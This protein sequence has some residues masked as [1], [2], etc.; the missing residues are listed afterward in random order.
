MI[1]SLLAN[2]KRTVAVRASGAD[3]PDDPFFACKLQVDD[4][5]LL[6]IYK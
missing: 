4:L 6:A 3:Q 1:N 5:L 2:G